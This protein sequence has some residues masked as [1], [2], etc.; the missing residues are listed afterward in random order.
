MDNH[1]LAMGT[2]LGADG[3]TSHE[4]E[5]LPVVEPVFG[6]PAL[7][8]TNAQKEKAELLG[9]TV[10]DPLSVL[11]THLTEV[12]KAHAAELLGRQEIRNM[13]DRVREESPALV[14]DLVPNLLTVGEVQRILQNLLDE[15]VSILD[16][17]AILETV[18]YHARDIKDPDTLSEYARL[19]LA[20]SLCNQYK[21]ANNLLHVITLSPAVEQMMSE[22]LQTTDQRRVLN[23]KPAVAQRILEGLGR[24]AEKLAGLGHQ[25]VVLCPSQIRLPLR[26]MVARVMPYLVVMAYNE[27][28]LETNVYT[29]GIVE[30]G[31]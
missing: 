3:D 18:A 17:P 19:A 15:R 24:E 2:G 11:S 5:G 26:R 1:Y 25:P 4:L 8:I 10:V 30:P 22:T 23:L 16:L 20:R 7:W 31:E 28:V 21:D 27:V 6:M 29:E 13:L 14:D 9:Y 12:I